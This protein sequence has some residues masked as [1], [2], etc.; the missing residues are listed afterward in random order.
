[1]IRFFQFVAC[2]AVLAVTLLSVHALRRAAPLFPFQPAGAG[3]SDARLRR[4]ALIDA[5]DA[6]AAPEFA[7]GSWINSEPLKLSSLRGRVVLVDFWTFGCYNCRN[8]LPALKRLHAAYAARGLTVVGV[9]SPEFDYEREVANVRRE[10]G[11]LGIHYAVITDNDYDTWRA[12]GVGAW[13]TVFILD[14]RGRV[15]YM[16]VGEGRYDEQERVVKTLLT[17]EYKEETQNKAANDFE[18]EAGGNF[19][20]GEERR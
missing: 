12:Y 7:V 14:K 20:E 4:D 19:G 18:R 1:M 6:P 15:R 8:T 17:E 11:S 13:P 16:H 9:H 5:K 10:V 3:H 2:A